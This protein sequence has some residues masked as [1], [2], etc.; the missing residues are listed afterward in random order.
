MK[1]KRNWL[2]IVMMIGL[3]LILVACSGNDDNNAGKAADGEVIKISVA[4]G[5]QS[6]EPIGKLA[7]KWKELAAEKSD[8]KLELVIY[9]SSQLGAEK[10]V[11]EQALMGNNIIALSGYDFLMDYVPDAGILT[12]PYLT[13]DFDSLLKLTTSDWFAD[14]ESR[15][16]DEGIDIINTNTFYG[17]RH[18]MTAK[19][20]ETLEDLRGLKIR[21]PNNQMYIKTFEALGASATPMP[22]GDLYTALQ[23]GLI[24]GAEN[25]L[26]VLEGSKV[27]E[28]IDNLTLTEHTKIMSPWISGTDFTET[29]PDDMLQILKETG[30]EAAEYARDIVEEENERVLTEFK[31]QGINIIEV[32]LEAFKE[33]AESVYT[34]FPEWS[35]GLYETVQDLIDE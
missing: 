3:V 24:D 8:G 30:N 7:E 34:E 5:N 14:L 13:D 22:L 26:P 28:V 16:N 11:A 21:V 25:P 6:E 1:I 20:V 10:D 29:L 31:E 27:N 15:L 35:D 2:S 9:P 17:E 18:L 4:H 32:D 33:K 23:Q 12:A 19:P